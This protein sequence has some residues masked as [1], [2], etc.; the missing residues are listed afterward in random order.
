MALMGGIIDFDV[1]EGGGGGS[2]WRADAAIDSLPGFEA[3]GE[4]MDRLAAFA[5]VGDAAADRLV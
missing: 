1:S 2:P 3:G 5:K 4:N